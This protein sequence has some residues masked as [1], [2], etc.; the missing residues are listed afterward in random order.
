MDRPTPAVSAP[1]A[2]VG[3]HQQLRA[4]PTRPIQQLIG[5]DGLAGGVGPQPSGDHRMG[6]ALGQPDQP[7]L[8]ERPA[9]S[10]RLLPGRP[11]TAA[12]AGVSATS[13]HVPSRLITRQPR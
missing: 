5:Q 2:T 9:R 6:A 4:E 8:G 12:L 1:Q 3:Q 11:N 13:R 7:E 10:P